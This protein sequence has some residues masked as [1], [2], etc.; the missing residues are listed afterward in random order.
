MD[1][2]LEARNIRKS[3]NEGRET[4]EVL[5]G[6]TL[7][8][9]PGEVVALE[10]PS[11]SGKSTL[12]SILGCM[13]TPSSGELVVGGQTIERRT[14]CA[15]VRRDRIGF[16]FQ[17]FHLLP[18]L[19]AV[20][21]VAYVLRLRGMAKAA[22]CAQ[23]RAALASVDLADRANFYPH[24]LS[25][26]QKQRVAIARALVGC[27]PVVLADEPT[28]NLDLHVGEQVLALFARVARER[29]AAL[30]VVTHDPKVRSVCDRVLTISAGAIAPATGAVARDSRSAP[31]FASMPTNTASFAYAAHSSARHRAC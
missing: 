1:P 26:G 24:E 17:Q 11:G 3:F 18:A 4:V 14:D 2:A 5:R 21:N 31:S 22:A 6:A 19:T 16:V 13:L 12:L 28:A 9:W 10:G 29:G 23:A 20:D 25:G 30:L 15:R 8:L 27:P 7:T